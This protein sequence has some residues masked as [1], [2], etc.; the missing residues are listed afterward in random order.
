MNRAAAVL[1]WFFFSVLSMTG[2]LSSF[3]WRHPSPNGNSLNGIAHLN[4]EFIAVGD[5]GTVL[6]SLRSSN[7][8]AW[9]FSSTGSPDVLSAIEYGNGRYVAIAE[10]SNVFLSSNL[11]HWA[12]ALVPA[13]NLKSIAFGNGMFVAV[14]E[15][16]AILT[17]TNG[18]SW[19]AESSGTSAPLVKV[20]F[21]AGVFVAV[22]E[23]SF[24][25]VSTNG[26]FWS[27]RTVHDASGFYPMNSEVL[28][29]DGK[30][31]IAGNKTFYVSHQSVFYMTFY[32]ST[33]GLVWN[34]VQSFSMNSGT[35]GGPYPPHAGVRPRALMHGNG[36]WLCLAT[37]NGFRFR[38]PDG[39][40]FTAITNASGLTTTFTDG[41]FGNG[42]FVLS[43]QEG[44]PLV[45]AN[46]IDWTQEGLAWGLALTSV[47]ELSNVCVA[48]GTHALNPAFLHQNDPGIIIVSSNRESFQPIAP[49]PPASL[50]SI[51]ANSNT[52]IAVG[53]N[54]TVMRSTNGFT[55]SQRPSN[56]AQDLRSVTFGTNR[57][58]AVGN[59]GSI[60][61]SSDGS[62]WSLRSSGTAL[63]LYSVTYARNQFVAVGEMGTVLVSLDG[64]NWDVQWAE[65]QE[66]LA[67]VAGNA[68]LFTAVSSSGSVFTSADG[69]TW[70]P[71]ATFA[72]YSLQSVTFAHDHFI[73]VGVSPDSNAQDGITVISGDGI[74]WRSSFVP[75]RRRIYGI[76]P[77][78]TG[79]IT[80][81]DVGAVFEMAVQS[82]PVI[83]I[84]RAQAGVELTVRCDSPPCLVEAST[85]C[86]IWNTWATATNTSTTFFL[87]GTNVVNQPAMFFRAV[88]P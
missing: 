50:S 52:L 57:F 53:R 21:G 4:G 64:V 77:T 19:K 49:P 63:N 17:S 27:P 69:I 60:I 1:G 23:M 58:V 72:P 45:S 71:R 13:P 3:Q 87:N 43:T 32:S 65:T 84:R 41:A 46:G 80:A 18:A 40:S 34:F 12:K 22:G 25:L 88:L 61:T 38:S 47:S 39:V 29:A 9:N 86:S 82:D 54:G 73:A 7:A 74:E 76:F 59:G 67:S 55:W 15:N 78:E 28:Y 70:I 35:L 68:N 2:A 85:D 11:T 51:S 36:Q 8:V 56:T 20:A 6:R 5:L 42:Q 16:G 62:I 44:Q 81:G 37:A 10:S 30:F 83:S 31:I 66:A 33:D 14:G 24:A 79:V 26:S 75:Q 48:V